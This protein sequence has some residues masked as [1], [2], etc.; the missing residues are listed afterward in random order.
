MAAGPQKFTFTPNDDMAM[1]SSAIE[2]VAAWLRNAQR[3]VVLSGAG[4]SKA[5]GIPTYRDADGLWMQGNNLLYSDVESFS[6]DPSGFRAFWAARRAQL[7]SAQPNAA[8][9]ALVELQRLRPATTLLTQN[10]DGLL[11]RAGA[12]RVLELHG[13]LTHNVCT[14]CGARDPAER[15]GHCLQCG[16]ARPTVRPAVVMFGERLDSK[17]LAEAQ[18][19]SKRADVFL[20]VG[21]TSV[22]Y[23]AASLSETARIRGAKHVVLNI[24]TPVGLNEA[25]AVVL[26]PAETTLP[27][28]VGLLRGAR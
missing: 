27:Q 24:D 9:H 18:F 4:L 6:T 15:D 13:T 3:I 2:Q 19:V 1:N 16:L 8:H 12:R 25:D 7:E 14:A 20:S 22:V 23:P 5:S 11:S 10:V 17:T 28:L 21:T 26:G